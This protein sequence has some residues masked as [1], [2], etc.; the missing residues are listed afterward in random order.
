MIKVRKAKMIVNRSGGKR[1]GSST[2][3]ATLPA[4]WVRKMGLSED[5][6]NLKLEFDGKTITIKNNEEEVKMLEKLLKKAMVEVDKEI[7]EMGYIDD[8]DNYERFLDGLANKL[9]VKEFVPDEDDIDLYYEKEGEIEQLAEE[10]LE[11]ITDYMKKTYNS[12]GDTNKSGKYTGCY[13]KNKEG[14]KNWRE[15]IE[16]K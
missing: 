1:G 11:D 5:A 2:F 8:S 7:S 3:R 6:R 10:L 4:S 16:G 13:Y 14:L 9:V 12:E 15:A